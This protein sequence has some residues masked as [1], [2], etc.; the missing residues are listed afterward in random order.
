MLE[1][2]IL[3]WF[4]IEA[5]KAARQVLIHHYNVKEV[6]Q[7]LIGYWQKYLSLKEQVPTMPTMGGSIMV[8]LAAMSTA[9]YEELAIRDKSKEE[10]AKLFYNI[11]W[12]IYI[13]MGKLSWLFASLGSKSNNQKLLKATQLFRAFPF[14]SPSYVWNDVSTRDNVVGFDCVKCPVA[15]YFKRNGLSKFCAETWCALDYP[16]AEMWGARL[17]RSGSIAGGAEKCDF[18]WSVDTKPLL[19]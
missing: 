11:A 4:K 10:I 2:I 3:F 7:I 19:K 16:L 17:E 8:H 14:N 18:R 15:E 6:Q 12:K 9:F 13:K 5:T 1:R